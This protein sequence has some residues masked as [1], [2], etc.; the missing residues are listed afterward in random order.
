MFTVTITKKTIEEKPAG[1][2]WEITGLDEPKFAYTPEITKKREVELK[3]YEQ[4]VDEID[5]KT[6][7]A[8]VNSTWG[9]WEMKIENT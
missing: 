6:V 4:T 3:I 9:K 2:E 7:I 1:R 5:I 8:A